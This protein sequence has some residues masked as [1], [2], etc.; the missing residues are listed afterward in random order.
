MVQSYIPTILIVVISWVSFWMD[1]DSVAGRTTLGVTTLLTL[2][3][4][5][6]GKKHINIWPAHLIHFRFVVPIFPRFHENFV[7]P[8]GRVINGSGH[9]CTLGD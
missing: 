4:K 5:S 3:S 2:S 8:W 7:G 6:A 1:V 9:F